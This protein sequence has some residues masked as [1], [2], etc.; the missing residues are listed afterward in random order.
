[1]LTFLTPTTQNIFSDSCGEEWRIT[2]QY[3]T[4]TIICL[5][6]NNKFISKINNIDWE[7]LSS[8]HRRELQLSFYSSS[9]K[10]FYDYNIIFF[11]WNYKFFCCRVQRDEQSCH[12]FKVLWEIEHKIQGTHCCHYNAYW[13]WMLKYRFL[14]LKVHFSD[15]EVNKWTEGMFMVV[16]INNSVF[17]Y[18]RI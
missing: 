14:R 7:I 6:S 9:I 10:F 15:M 5:W 12:I 3:A 13:K 8:S 1:M 2:L 16:F 11:T 4:W 17:Y 18:L